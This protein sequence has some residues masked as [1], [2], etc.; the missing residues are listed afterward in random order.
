MSWPSQF[1]K[2]RSAWASYFISPSGRRRSSISLRKRPAGSSSSRRNRRASPHRF[3]LRRR[4]P[5][6]YHP[7]TPTKRH[8]P[9]SKARRVA[10]V[11]GS[12][13]RS[14]ASSLDRTCP[15]FPA[16]QRFAGIALSFLKANSLDLGSGL[17]FC[18]GKNGTGPIS[19]S[20]TICDVTHHQFIGP[21]L[22]S[23]PSF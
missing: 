16:I 9:A 21:V 18:G 7:P 6:R 14:N 8:P 2:Q 10:A 15:V 13:V 1:S 19:A 23:S 17:P 12:N 5:S 22:F 11:A 20:N 3:R 4:F